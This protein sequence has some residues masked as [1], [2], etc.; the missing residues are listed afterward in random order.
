MGRPSAVEEPLGR[1]AYFPLF[2]RFSTGLPSSGCV[3]KPPTTIRLPMIRHSHVMTF[4]L[5]PVVLL[6]L[7]SGVGQAGWAFRPSYFTHDPTDG[8]RVAKYA[9][10]T[11]PMR[12]VDPT[13]VQSAYRH[14]RSSVRVGNSADRLH[15]VETW[16]EGDRIRPYGEWQRPF[17]EGATPFGPW[18]NPQG[19]WTTPY[20]SWFNPFALGQLPHPPWPHWGPAPYPDWGA[21]SQA[22]PPGGYR[23]GPGG[24]DRYKPAPAPPK[25]P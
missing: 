24:H 10:E 17:R 25:G 15:V 23:R 21:A 12:R 18:G 6:L 19:P 5:A 11:Q 4:G 13:Y 20:G 8:Q 3:G 22:A 7:W 9:P 2:L 16:G 1:I 14:N